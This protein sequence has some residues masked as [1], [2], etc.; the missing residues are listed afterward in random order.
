MTT[1]PDRAE[2]PVRRLVFA[3]GASRL[4]L[5]AA[6]GMDGLYSA[7]FEEPT[8]DIE[9]ANETVTVRYPGRFGLFDWR[10]RRYGEV[11]LN[12]AVP[13][14]IEVRGGASEV[15]AELGGLDLLGLE[16]RGGAS[17]FRVE[18]PEPSGVVPVRISGGASE[19]VVRRP[20][21]VAAGL[22]LE[23]GAAGLA[24]DDQRFGAVSSD[25]R[26]QSP[27]YGEA[28]RRYDVEVSGGASKL[29][30]TSG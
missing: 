22:R 9:V 16:V 10:G 14:R 24:F 27:G 4:T 17:T 5:R 2:T 19:I 6:S 1:R 26:L 23:G 3:D 15:V 12:T 28:A 13:W 18:L 7:R 20:P 21:G 11:V 8:P 25:M 30:L 29:A